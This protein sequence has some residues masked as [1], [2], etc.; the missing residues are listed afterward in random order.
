MCSW[1]VASL[2]DHP[3]SRK[4]RRTNG[5]WWAWPNLFAQTEAAHLALHGEPAQH[6]CLT[7]KQGSAT[8]VYAL[9]LGKGPNYGS[10]RPLK[11]GRKGPRASLR[12]PPFRRE[13]IM[14]APWQGKA[15]PLEECGWLSPA[16]PKE[17]VS[18]CGSSKTD[19]L[20]A[21]GRVDKSWLAMLE[22]LR[23]TL[24]WPHRQ[25]RGLRSASSSARCF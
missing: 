9:P 3:S 15:G 12:I 2:G 17:K 10:T 6:M 23:A 22:W 16:A 24:V 1:V 4:E 5:V 19:M 11:R 20:Q 14:S 8:C 7:L 13:G 21:V 25:T 18:E